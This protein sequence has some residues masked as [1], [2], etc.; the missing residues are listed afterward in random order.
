MYLEMF[1]TPQFNGWWLA[2]IRPENIE[3]R[4]DSYTL[5]HQLKPASRNNILGQIRGFFNY[6][7]RRGWVPSNP[8]RDIPKLKVRNARTRWI[9]PHELE[10]ILEHCEP[11]LSDMVSFTIRTGLRLG[12]MLSLRVGDFSLDAEGR[13]WIVVR[14][15]KNG[16]RH[17][18]PLE[19]TTRRMVEKLII[20]LEIRP[21]KRLFP[22]PKGGNPYSS[23]RRHFRA[24]VLKAGLPYGE[25]SDGI[26]WHSLRHSFASLALNAGVSES[27]IM[28]LGNWRTRSMVQRYGHLADLTLRQGA[29]HLDS[30]LSDADG[31][32]D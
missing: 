25:A 10:Q 15:T 23:I 16:R 18:V 4:L 29:A 13:A 19:G 21:E 30:I 14:E 26:T 9:R 32:V 24:A 5:E 3:D 12:E 27:V 28:R 20:Q 11:W 31:D 8:C 22:G 1:W 7:K 17:P 2:D 6:C